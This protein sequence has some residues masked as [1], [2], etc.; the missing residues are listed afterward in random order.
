MEN[1]KEEKTEQA[2]AEQAT[3]QTA[4]QDKEKPLDKNGKNE[5]KADKKAAKAAKRAQKR[6]KNKYSIT[7]P[8]N[9]RGRH[10]MPFMNFLRAIC[11]PVYKFIFPFRC[12]GNYKTADGA[13]VYVCNHY[14]IWDPVYIALTTTEGIHILA[15]REVTENAF[16]K[17]I[18]RKIRCISVNRDGSDVRALMDALK[19]LKNGEKVSLFPEGTR[20]KTEQELLP[21]KP[22]AALMAIKAKVP[23]VPV[24]IYKKQM[25]FKRAHILYGEPFYLSEFYD[26][27]M[28]EEDWNAADERI[29]N[30]ILRL[31][32]EHAE[33]LA[34]KKQKGKAEQSR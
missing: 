9:K 23:V 30:E 12:Y 5:K 10:V 2:A 22:G 18:C 15:K 8:A 21:F 11:I 29:K 3:E 20:N 32:R 19:C 27:K 28:T 33:F 34:A 14:R 7:I 17:P 6:K 1:G 26:K 24:A 16:M 4:A 31:K 13:C 25:P